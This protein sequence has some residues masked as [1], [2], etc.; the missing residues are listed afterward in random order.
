M[1]VEYYDAAL[2]GVQQQ[3][4]RWIQEARTKY[5]PYPLVII[6]DQVAMAGEVNTYRISRIVEQELQN[7]S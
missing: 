5:W 6:N 3:F 2:P 7:E 1:Q 4:A